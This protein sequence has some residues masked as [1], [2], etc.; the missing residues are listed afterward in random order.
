VKATSNSFGDQHGARTLCVAEAVVAAETGK[1]LGA[2]LPVTRANRAL[3]RFVRAIHQELLQ[4]RVLRLCSNE[5]RN[6]R[7]CVLPQ[8]EEILVGRLGFGGVAL[9]GVSSGEAQPG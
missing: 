9:Q 5:D 4:L 3:T 6:I 1:V 7:V 2:K 8:R